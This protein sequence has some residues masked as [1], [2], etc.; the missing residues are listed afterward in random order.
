MPV[1]LNSINPAL[2]QFCLKH[3]DD[4]RFQELQQDRDP[5]DYEW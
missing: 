2:L 1:D 4:E 3:H 5:S